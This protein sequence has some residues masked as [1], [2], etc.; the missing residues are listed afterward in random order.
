M[1]SKPKLKRA[2]PALTSIQRKCLLKFFMKESRS[3]YE[4]CDERTKHLGLEGTL[5]EIEKECLGPR[6]NLKIDA[7]DENNFTIL[8]DEDCNGKFEPLYVVEHGFEKVCEEDG[9]EI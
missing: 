7:I 2:R 6:P 3:Y 4:T 8:F 1:K 9:D 5:E